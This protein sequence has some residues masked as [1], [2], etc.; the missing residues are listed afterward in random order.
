MPPHDV[1]DKTDE[2]VFRVKVSRE[3]E[4]LADK[5]GYKPYM[6]QRYLEVLGREETIELLE[7]NETPLPKTIRCNSYL[8][9]C[10]VLAKRLSGKGFTVARHPLAPHGL[11]IEEEPIPVGATHEYLLG[12]Y[13]VQDP[14]SMMVTY[15]LEPLPGEVILDLAAAPGGKATHIQQ[16]TNDSSLLVAV[17]VSRERVR[18]LRSNMQRMGFRNYVIVRADLRRLPSGLMGDRVLLDAPSSGEGI[19]RKDP[20]RKTSRSL[21]DLRAVH[22][23]QIELLESAFNHVKPGGVLVYAACSTAVEEGEYVIHKLLSSREDADVEPV[24]SVTGAPGIDEYHGVV[25]DSRV[26]KCLR[27]WPHI[28]DTEGFFICRLKRRG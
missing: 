2:K 6:V 15:A 11:I 5:Y 14:G 9:D 10:S 21:E 23:R 24:Y 16:L 27:L 4:L 12:Y 26:R 18:A 20:S 3:A 22:T 17:E 1:W 28:H 19:I 7:A 25:F 13:Y 8:V